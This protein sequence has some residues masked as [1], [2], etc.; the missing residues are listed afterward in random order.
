MMVLPIDSTR[1]LLV[2]APPTPQFKDRANGVI[3]TDR[4]TGQPL[5]DISLALPV[6]GGA[7]TVPEAAGIE[8]RPLNCRDCTGSGTVSMIHG[9]RNVS[10][11]CRT[12]HGTGRRPDATI[13]LDEISAHA[14]ALIA[15]CC[16]LG[17]TQE[18]EE[19]KLRRWAHMLGF[20]GHFAT[21]S[22]GYSTTFAALCQERAVFSATRTAAA[23][24]LP[25]DDSVTV[26]NDWRYVGPI[27]RA[28]PP[29]APPTVGPDAPADTGPT[30]GRR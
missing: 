13:D 30:G 22:R 27:V 29:A 21:K 6:D 25:N 19:L 18:F 5:A 4:D 14:R 24:G 28:D 7:P 16:R 2:L 12:C 17:G 26:I 10:R 15:A 1:P 3:A 23:L 11:A 20:R 9:D 8:L